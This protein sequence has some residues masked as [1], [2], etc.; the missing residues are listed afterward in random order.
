MQR[1]AI[2]KL[3]PSSSTS[4]PMI[5]QH[6]KQRNSNLSKSKNR[7]LKSNKRMVK[8]CIVVAFS[9]IASTIMIL[10][11]AY[12]WDWLVV[13]ND[14]HKNSNKL[15]SVTTS[16]PAS[17]AAAAKA[18]LRSLIRRP[19][20]KIMNIKLTSNYISWHAIA[21]ELASL[22]PSQTLEKLRTLDPFGVR[23]FDMALKVKETKLQ[24]SLEKEELKELWMCPNDGEYITKEVVESGPSEMKQKSFI[25]RVQDDN[26]NKQRVPDDD[27]NDDDKNDDEDDVVSLK[28]DDDGNKSGTGKTFLF[29]QHLR[30]AGGTF[31]CDLA[32]RNL[33]PKRLPDYYCMP[34]YKWTNYKNA[35]YLHDFTNKDI[36]EKM[37]HDGF[38]IAGNEWQNFRKDSDNNNKKGG[39]SNHL[40][41]DAVFATSFRN[42][43]D[44]ALSQFRF[45]CVEDRGCKIKTIEEWWPRRNDLRNIYVTTFADV[46]LNNW[47][48][49]SSDIGN[50]QDGGGSNADSATAKANGRKKAVGAALNVISQY[51]LILSMEWLSYAGPLV[52]ESLGFKDTS[53]LTK[54]VRPHVNQAKRDEDNVINNHGAAG[55]SE[56]SWSAE[57]KIGKSMFKIMSEDLALD[58]ILNDAARRIFLERLLCQ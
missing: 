11:L 23:T 54:R 28:G 53:S 26:N 27:K 51:H 44:R 10:V 35:G 8:R 1:A 37:D 38:M 3:P 31:F 43:V 15:S 16:L 2:T 58:E 47:K 21:L 13:G 45:E 48:K 30:K 20:K 4:L 42:P 6:Q 57:Q 14:I 50:M 39:N 40:N 41:L 32:T 5:K 34:D 49:I 46:S 36:Q 55:I 17:K 33:A 7:K 19:S 25:Q 24:R 9:L 12:V 56:A 52:T 29:F 18:A 22:P